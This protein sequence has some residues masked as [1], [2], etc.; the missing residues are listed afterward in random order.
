MS[1]DDKKSIVTGVS[2][3][4]FLVFTLIF[5][6]I[7]FVSILF[8]G[9][10]RIL[11]YTAVS[12]PSFAVIVPV[13][14]YLIISYSKRNKAIVQYKSLILRI[15]GTLL[16]ISSIISFGGSM[17]HVIST[18]IQIAQIK[19]ILDIIDLQ[20]I[21]GSLYAYISSAALYFFQGIIGLILTL[22]AKKK[23]TEC[24]QKSVGILNNEKSSE[25]QTTTIM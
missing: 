24:I 13:M 19:D 21:Y 22:V 16:I 7:R 8:A 10:N 18:L 25:T 5:L 12:L 4:Y 1:K 9:V 3:Y 23:D 11:L 2:L 6:L 20:F 17:T 15:S 14:V